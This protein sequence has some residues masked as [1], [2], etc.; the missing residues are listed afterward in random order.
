MA[1]GGERTGLTLLDDIA[2][3]LGHPQPDVVIAGGREIFNRL[4]ARDV[5]LGARRPRAGVVTG[6]AEPAG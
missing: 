5:L 4:H 2:R 3:E 6:G 1:E